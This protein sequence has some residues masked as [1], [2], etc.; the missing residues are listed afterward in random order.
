[1]KVKVSRACSPHEERR[2]EYKVLKGKK[3]PL[4]RPRGMWVD[5][6]KIEIK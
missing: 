1:V 2:N 6:I 3:T 4:A 5:N